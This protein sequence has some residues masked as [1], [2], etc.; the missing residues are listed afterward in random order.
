MYAERFILAKYFLDTKDKWL[1]DHFFN[2]CLT[3][4]RAIEGDG[5]QAQ[6][7]GHRNVGLSLKESGECVNCDFHDCS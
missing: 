7:E 4:S 3:T 5:G 6:A 1:S 2:T